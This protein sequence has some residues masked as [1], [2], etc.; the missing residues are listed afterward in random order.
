MNSSKYSSTLWTAVNKVLFYE[1]AVNKVL[2]YE[3]W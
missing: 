2:L 1:T 3:Q